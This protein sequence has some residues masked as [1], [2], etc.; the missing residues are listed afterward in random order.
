MSAQFLRSIGFGA[1]EDPDLALLEVVRY[2]CNPDFQP[3]SFQSGANALGDFVAE[4]V[5]QQPSGKFEV[6]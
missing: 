3:C 2:A 5:V 4:D 1:K 6:G